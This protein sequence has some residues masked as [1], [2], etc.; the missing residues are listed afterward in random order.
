MI[1]Y[2]LIFNE[3]DG[4][5]K[6]K[7]DADFSL[8]E[9][10][11]RVDLFRKALYNVLE[12][13]SKEL[14]DAFYYKDY[15]FSDVI[16][17]KPYKNIANI[18]IRKGSNAHRLYSKLISTLFKNSIE[19]NETKYKI[20]DFVRMDDITIAP[21]KSDKAIK[22]NLVTPLLLFTKK[23]FPIYYAISKKYTDTTTR[24]EELK[25][26]A[27]ELI[28]SNLKWQLQQLK[29][30]KKYDMLDQIDI[31]WHDFDIKFIEYHDNEK[32][33]PAIFGSFTSNWELPHFIGHK[34]G[35]GFGQINKARHFR[36]EQTGSKNETNNA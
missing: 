24:D 2:S 29:K 25:R 5:G 20:T 14:Y 6:Y 18:Y 35:K 10:K 30:Y 11:K 12:K 9:N 34:I 17:Q 8:I 1:K 7:Q 32:K 15:G 13:E 28:I 22:Y 19:I 26:K 16:F 3:V 21:I 27:K 23:K 4:E 33:T 31:N 36:N